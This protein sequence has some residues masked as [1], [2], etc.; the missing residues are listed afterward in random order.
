MTIR[1][2]VP[3]ALAAAVILAV[4]A[5]AIAGSPHAIAAAKNCK[6]Q[7]KAVKKAEAK[8]AKKKA[9]RVLRK[10]HP[11]AKSPKPK[12]ARRLPLL[13]PRL[14][15][16]PRRPSLRQPKLRTPDSARRIR[17]AV[18]PLTAHRDGG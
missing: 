11:A 13:R 2:T 14:S 9:K 12:P 7:R 6:E 3:P 17:R 18:T 16:S 15:L 5:P 1:K 4:A 8:K 10:C